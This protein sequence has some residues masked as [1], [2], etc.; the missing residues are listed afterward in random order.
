MLKAFGFELGKEDIELAKKVMSVISKEEESSVTDLKSFTPESSRGDILFL[1]GQRAI[2]H[3]KDMQC[4]EYF[5][6]PKLHQLRDL[7]ENETHR[8]SAFSILTDYL[9]KKSGPVKTVK[10]TIFK[11]G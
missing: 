8:T 2:N 6:L 1:F 9:D 11:K 3:C 5:F 7:P 10:K 4:K